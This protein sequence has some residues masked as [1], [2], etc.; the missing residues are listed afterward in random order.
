MEVKPVGK[1]I[2]NSDDFGYSKGVNYGIIDAF[3]DGILTSTTIMAN[4]PGFEHAVKLGQQ[5]TGLGIGVHLTLTCGNPILKNINTLV[6]EF[7]EFKSKKNYDN[8]LKVNPDEVKCEWDAQIQRVLRSGI[9]PTHLDSHHHIHTYGNNQEIVIELARKYDLPIR[10]NFNMPHDIKQ[11]EYFEPLF[12]EV[13]FEEKDRTTDL[14]AY[15]K[16]LI[17]KIHKY[18]SVEIMCHCAYLDE[19]LDRQN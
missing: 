5:H 10:S 1:V 19:F 12:D 2:F 15:L 8:G 6:N 9:T 18:K 7:G 11:V 3:T 14:D 13:G 16:E 4:M 17:Q